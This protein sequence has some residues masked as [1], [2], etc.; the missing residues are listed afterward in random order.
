MLLITATLWRK[1]VLASILTSGAV[2]SIS[3]VRKHKHY[4]HR[5]CVTICALPLYC[6]VQSALLYIHNTYIRMRFRCTEP[7]YDWKIVST[8]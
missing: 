1:V 2:Y 5:Y 6:S 8:L 4:D 7:K 3:T